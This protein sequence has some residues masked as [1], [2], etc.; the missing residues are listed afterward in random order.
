MNLA[1][2]RFLGIS[3]DLKLWCLSVSTRTLACVGIFMLVG[4]LF[5]LVCIC[6]NVW[7]VLLWRVDFDHMIITPVFAFAISQGVSVIIF[8]CLPFYPGVSDN[9]LLQYDLSYICFLT[10]D[11]Y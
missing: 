6:R 10:V 1:S 5:H 2:L 4:P 11:I 3:Q 8:V 9:G 7:Y